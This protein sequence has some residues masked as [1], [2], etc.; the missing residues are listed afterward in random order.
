MKTFIPKPKRY[1][2]LKAQFKKDG[3]DSLFVISDF[4]KTLTYASVNGNKTPSLISLLRDGDHLKADYAGKAHALFDKYHPIEID[5]QISVQE[6][7]KA[8]QEWWESHTKL[9]I[10]SG[11]TKADLKDIIASD[12]V[13]FRKGALTFFDF[14]HEHNIPLIIFSASGCGEAV[15]LLF[16]HL[17]KDYSNM[18]FVI[19]RFNWNPEGRAVSRKGA[20]IH[21]YNK[22][23]AILKKYPLIKTTIADR[24]NALLLGDGIGDTNMLAH[25]DYHNAIK[26]GF[27]NADADD[28]NYEESKDVYKKNFDLILEGDGNFK[29]V[30]NLLFELL[31]K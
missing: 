3:K 26:I 1:Q 15:E 25:I 29:V 23:G 4:D 20:I 22:D 13:K 11:L 8:M 18:H 7:K 27:F 12:R 6:K 5:P 10:E 9:L 19:N 2:K 31:E 21:S 16:Q 28:A 17:N 24:K 14:L 30:N